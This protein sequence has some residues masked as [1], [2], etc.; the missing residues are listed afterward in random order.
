MAFT[1]SAGSPVTCSS[2][3]SR[4]RPASSTPSTT[5]PTSPPRTAAASGAVDNALAPRSLSALGKTP[6]AVDAA[7]RQEQSSADSADDI[8]RERER[9]QE[10]AAYRCAEHHYCQTSDHAPVP[11]ALTPCLSVIASHPQPAVLF[12]NG[13]ELPLSERDDHFFASSRSRCSSSNR[14][15]PAVPSSPPRAVHWH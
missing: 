5:A 4:S 8:A 3:I 6:S 14:A 7:R 1:T 9:D 12:V 13:C 2:S 11:H 10:H 15:R